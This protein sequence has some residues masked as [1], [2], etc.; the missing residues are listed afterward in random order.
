[1]TTKKYEFTGEMKKFYGLTLK[2][3]RRISDGAIGGWIESE[4]NLS[5]EGEC[6]VY[7]EAVVCGEAKV[8][9]EARVCGEAVV[10]GKAEVY[11]KARVFDEAEV[12]GEAVVTEGGIIGKVTAPFKF[13]FQFQC[14]HR[15]LT[16][17]LTETDEILYSIG[18]QIEITKETFLDRIQNENGGLN[19]N[20]HRHE[21]LIVMELAENYFEQM[22][23]E[24]SQEG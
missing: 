6:F 7:D 19:K 16:A 4:G 10:F 22:K 11:G 20:P 3:I 2:R 24:Y 13:I 14:Q 23:A 8:F 17:V 1:M 21:Y 5:H 18:C 15:V 9:D 12:Y